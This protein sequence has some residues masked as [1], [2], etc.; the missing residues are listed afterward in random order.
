MF[1]YSI[2][3]LQAQIGKLLNVHIF[4]NQS[5]Y[6]LLVGNVFHA[7]SRRKMTNAI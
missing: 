3:L 7:R 2:Y 5:Q 6:N 4:I 1:Y